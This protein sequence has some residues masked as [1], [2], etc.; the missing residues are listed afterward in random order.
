M[1]LVQ[2]VMLPD[3]TQTHLAEVVLGG[4][5]KAVPEPEAGFQPDA[6]MFEFYEGVDARLQTYIVGVDRNRVRAAVSEYLAARAGGPRDFLA[7]EALAGGE[8]LI[9]P[10]AKAFGKLKTRRAGGDGV[11]TGAGFW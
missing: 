6:L 11:P 7:A 8:A 1:R 2:E 9:D 5:M 3:S 10:L 4:L